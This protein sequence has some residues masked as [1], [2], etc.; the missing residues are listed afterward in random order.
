[1]ERLCVT[2]GDVDLHQFLR[3][4]LEKQTDRQTDSGEN[5]IHV[6]AVDVTI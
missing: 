2:F 3:H 6:T 1:M 5:P 4:C